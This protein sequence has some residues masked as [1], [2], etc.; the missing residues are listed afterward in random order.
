MVAANTGRAEVTADT[1]NATIGLPLFA[2]DNLWDDGDQVTADRLR[3][4][5][6]S[7]TSSGSSFRRYPGADVRTFGT[8]P[9]SL[10]LYG[11]NDR[12]SQIS[13]VFAN[14]GDIDSLLGIVPETG[15]RNRPVG[16]RVTK[17]Y[18]AFIEQD[19]KTIGGAL[20]HLFGEP[21]SDRV[22]QGRET[23]EQVDRWDWN[24]H[25]FLL[26]SPRQEYVALRVVPTAS[27]DGDPAKRIP[28]SEVRARLEA[29]VEKRANG[30]V[31]IQNIPMVDQ[32]PKG[33]CVPATWERTLRYMG[34]PADMYVLAM[35]GNT[36][37]G[38]GTTIDDIVAG[39]GD[40]VRRSGRRLQQDAGRVDIRSLSKSI[41]RG[42]PV[43][44][45]MFVDRDLDR[46][47]TFRS[48]ERPSVPDPKVW[49][50]RLTASRKAARQLRPDRESGH[51]CM[52][53]GYN[54]KTQ[55]I[56]ISDS[57]GREFAERWI[58]VEEADAISQGRFTTILW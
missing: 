56:A 6:E 51:V 18:Q 35:A 13:V 44:W 46:S 19:A 54:E 14:K 32:G 25:S 11:E 41:D 15:D 1:V 28:D 27:L 29:N 33:Y 57:W 49:S 17:K 21:K 34:I 52:I 40:V 50:E 5:L 42:I 7:K 37:V 36:N 2:D 22:G 45:A 43:M 16:N 48:R 8:R 10:A 38:G 47:V 24:G 3:W 53:I 39:V 58:T 9:F 31:V 20:T 26:A 23:R 12:V 30:D 4:P 55:E